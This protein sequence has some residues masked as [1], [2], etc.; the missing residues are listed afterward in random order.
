[1]AIN[2]VKITS[3]SVNAENSIGSVIGGTPNSNPIAQLK[4]VNSVG[5]ENLAEKGI[6]LSENATTCEIMECIADVEGQGSGGSGGN[7][8][9]DSNGI[10]TLNASIDSQGTVNL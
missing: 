2:D 10:V 3:K 4:Q 5:I 7:V 9:I 6:T 8:T 1:M